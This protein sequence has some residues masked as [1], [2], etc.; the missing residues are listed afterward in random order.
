M[1]AFVFVRRRA[2]KK[3]RQPDDRQK[4]N[5]WKWRESERVDWTQ[6]VFQHVWIFVN[7]TMQKNVFNEKKKKQ[8][9]KNQKRNNNENDDLHHHSYWAKK[10]FLPRLYSFDSRISVVILKRYVGLDSI[11]IS[12]LKQATELQNK[13]YGFRYRAWI[14]Y[15]QKKKKV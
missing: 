13:A 4:K 10:K 7:K 12:V 5:L 6:I 11:L 1:V 14:E 15:E 8:R 9:K 3:K 2:K